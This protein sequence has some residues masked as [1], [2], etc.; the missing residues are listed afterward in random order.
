MEIGPIPGIRPLPATKSPTSGPRLP[1]VFDVEHSSEPSEDT[2]S[3]SHSAAGGQDDQEDTNETDQ[4]E[5]TES[6]N[7]PT[8]SIDLIA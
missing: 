2:Y 8:S 1:A 5:Q 4:P 3:G 7:Q 6:P